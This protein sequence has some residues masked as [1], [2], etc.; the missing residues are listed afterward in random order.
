[1]RELPRAGDSDSYCERGDYF[2][3]QDEFDRAI[4]DYTSAIRLN[5]RNDRAYFLRGRAW[6]EKDEP[7]QAVT[8][9]RKAIALNWNNTLQIH[10]ARRLL[11]SHG[12][13]LDRLIED[14]AMEHLEDLEVVSG[15]AVGYS[16]SPGSFYTISLVI[17]SPFEDEKFL[18]MAQN[19]NPVIRAMAM[20]CL[21]REDKLK[22]ESQVRS[23]YT[24]T[25]E[26]EY[27]PVGC[28]MSRITLDKLA[29]S[30]I[31]DP[32]VL[33]Y[34]SVTHTDWISSR[35]KRD[36]RREDV[37]QRQVEVIRVLISEGVDIDARDRLGETPLHYAAEH[38]SINVGEVLITNGAKVNA[39]NNKGETPLH[40]STF[41]GYQKMVELLMASGADITA[42]TNGGQ[43]TVDIAT[44]QDYPGLR[45]LLQRFEQKR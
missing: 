8:D 19:S 42:K 17:S 35:S 3:W 40:R 44:Q 41:W 34:W 10:Y 28:G 33:D 12:T 31:D 32:D 45:T 29:K 7:Q 4:E 43:T 2:Y 1:V 38:G 30:I 22:Y 11:Q 21:A 13:E 37:L 9:W 23:F 27:M 16:G 25:A 39:N 14:T 6:A 18:Q 36:S 26:V 15:Y 24:D 20:I 5:S